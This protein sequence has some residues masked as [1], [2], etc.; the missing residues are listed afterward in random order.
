MDEGSSSEREQQDAR[1]GWNAP[2]GSARVK[3]WGVDVGGFIGASR[4]AFETTGSFECG[5]VAEADVAEQR[6]QHAVVWRDVQARSLVWAIGEE[7]PSLLSMTRPATSRRCGARAATPL[8]RR[9]FGCISLLHCPRLHTLSSLHV[10]GK[11]LCPTPS[12]LHY[13]AGSSYSP[14]PSAAHDQS[15]LIIASLL[16]FLPAPPHLIRFA[17]APSASPQP[18]NSSSLPTQRPCWLSRDRIRHAACSGAACGQQQRVR[19]HGECR[20][21]P[22]CCLQCVLICSVGVHLLVAVMMHDALS[23]DSDRE[24]W[25]WRRVRLRRWWRG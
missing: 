4:A 11:W 24:R 7:S 19:V 1:E 20:R 2:Y 23:R 18:T 10:A 15:P 16:P 5:R 13:L 17:S 8:L 21:L 9:T 14:S 3:G 22:R 6:Q 12:P 25:R